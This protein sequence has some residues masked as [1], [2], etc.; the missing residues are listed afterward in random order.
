MSS[1]PS[2][3]LHVLKSNVAVDEASSD[4]T[5]DESFYRQATRVASLS[6]PPRVTTEIPQDAY[7]RYSKDD[8]WCLVAAR[9]RRTP[10]GELDAPSPCC[11]SSCGRAWTGRER[12]QAL[13]AAA[14]G[15]QGSDA[16]STGNLSV[17]ASVATVNASATS[18]CRENRMDAAGLGLCAIA[19]P[20]RPP[21]P[22]EERCVGIC[23]SPGVT[24]EQGDSE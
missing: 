22:P 2:W 7:S 19:G 18:M 21:P 23:S 6:P 3:V 24:Q 1:L 9:G 11:Y 16:L 4:A 15:V 20:S 10:L 12:T 14:T 8:S 17:A 5:H 13:R